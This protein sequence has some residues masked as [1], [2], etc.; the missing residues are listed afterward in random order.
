VRDKDVIYFA[1]A[2]INPPA[3]FISLLNQLISPVVTARIL[4]R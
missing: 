4:T 2:E 1:N 3:K